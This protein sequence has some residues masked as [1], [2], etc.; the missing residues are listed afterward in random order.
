MCVCTRAHRTCRCVSK[1]VGVWCMCPCL[2]MPVHGYPIW[3]EV[4]PRCP[5]TEV[6]STVRYDGV[7]YWLGPHRTVSV[8][9]PMR[10]SNHLFLLPRLCDY[11]VSHR[12]LEIEP[13]PSRL[14]GE[15][16]LI[17]PSPQAYTDGDCMK[18]LG[19]VWGGAVKTLWCTCWFCWKLTHSSWSVGRTTLAAVH[20]WRNSRARSLVSSASMLR[21]GFV[22]SFGPGEMVQALRGF[23]ALAGEPVNFLTTTQGYSQPPVPL[24]P[25]DLMQRSGLCRHPH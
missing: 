14:H 6:V 23:G 21:C 2:C 17:E 4:N 5:S 15:H 7:P 20:S 12:G 25:R 11:S 19:C 13:W 1:F 16:F 24:V 10:L 9:W 22:K 3:L 8:H 18:T